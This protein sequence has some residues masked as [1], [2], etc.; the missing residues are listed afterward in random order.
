MNIHTS[1]VSGIHAAIFLALFS[2]VILLTAQDGDTS[3]EEKKAISQNLQYTQAEHL[4]DGTSFEYFYKEGGG[5]KIAFYKGQLKY[6][7][8]SGQRKGNSAKDKSY[9]SRI[10]GDELFMVNWQEKNKPDFVTLIID[11]K[12]NA[13]Y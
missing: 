12:Q 4:L 9:Q 7:W 13:L 8:I 3:A 11:L 6:E 10:I 2:P 5:L 1:K